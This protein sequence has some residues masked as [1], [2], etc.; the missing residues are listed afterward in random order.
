MPRQLGPIRVDCDA[1]P[2]CVVEAST[3][4]GIESPADVP[5]YRLSHLTKG[6]GPALLRLRQ[7][8]VVCR[9]GEPLSE[10]CVAQFNFLSGAVI[11]YLLVQCKRCHA[12]YWERVTVETNQEVRTGGA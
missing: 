12:V 1:P 4:V 7:S 8:G 2:Y 6:P 9:C 11:D 3:K 5:W 10:P